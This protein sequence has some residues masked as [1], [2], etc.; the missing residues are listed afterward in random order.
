MFTLE[1]RE[2]EGEWRVA[3][4]LLSSSHLAKGKMEGGGAYTAVIQGTLSYI[5]TT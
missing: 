5:H 1:E 3:V 4:M 2:G